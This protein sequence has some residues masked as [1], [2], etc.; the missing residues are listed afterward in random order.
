[1]YLKGLFSSMDSVPTAFISY[2]YMESSWCGEV[3]LSSLGIT[4]V[5]LKVGLPEE[6]TLWVT[7]WVNS[8]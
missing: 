8:R 4:K 7:L 1:M 5:I 3:V 2:H 6:G